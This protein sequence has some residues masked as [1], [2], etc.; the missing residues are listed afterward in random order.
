MRHDDPPKSSTTVRL[1]HGLFPLR[2]HVARAF[3]IIGT[4]IWRQ[5]VGKVAAQEV[6]GGAAAGGS[7]MA[8]ET[9]VEEGMV[10]MEEDVRE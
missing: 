6:P 10:L 3:P 9:C 1:S 8:L 4:P 7:C 2:R 5:M